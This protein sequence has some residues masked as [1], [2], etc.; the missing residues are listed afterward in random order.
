MKKFIW[1]LRLAYLYFS[2]AKFS[3]SYSWVMAKPSVDEGMFEDGYSP[4]NDFDE[5]VLCWSK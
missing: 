4:R 5:E 2:L 1:T 3:L